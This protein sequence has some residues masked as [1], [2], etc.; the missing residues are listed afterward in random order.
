[1]VNRKELTEEKD[2]VIVDRETDV[3]H[4]VTTFKEALEHSTKGS[5]MTKTYYE[6]HYKSIIK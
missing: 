2:W 1:M 3:P 4:Y 6:N 5:V